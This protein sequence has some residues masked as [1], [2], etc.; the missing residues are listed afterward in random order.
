MKLLLRHQQNAY[1]L[2]MTWNSIA[3]TKSAFDRFSFNSSKIC[4]NPCRNAPKYKQTATKN[5][6]YA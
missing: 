6:K 1:S 2:T 3:S 4:W 5:D